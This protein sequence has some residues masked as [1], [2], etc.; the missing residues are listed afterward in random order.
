MA[1]FQTKNANMGKNLEC[2]AMKEVG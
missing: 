2:L 1:Y